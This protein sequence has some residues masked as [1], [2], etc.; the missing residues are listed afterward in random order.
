[1]PLIDW[2]ARY[3]LPEE[4]K[5][6]RPGYARAVAG[7]SHGWVARAR[8]ARWFRLA[9]A[10]D[11]DDGSPRRARGRNITSGLVLS[12]RKLPKACCTHGCGPLGTAPTCP[13]LAR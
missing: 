11:M 6:A 3:A 7:S 8:P 13:A 12:D 1:M 4:C 5:L 2:L 9:F 10:P